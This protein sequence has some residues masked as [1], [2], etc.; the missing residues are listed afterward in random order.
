MCVYI[1]AS[2]VLMN[3]TR[4]E[5][6]SRGSSCVQC[7]APVWHLHLR[8]QAKDLFVSLLAHLGY[9]RDELLVWLVILCLLVFHFN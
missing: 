5:T 8:L 7:I 4:Q 6:R 9:A 3:S 1:P 2:D